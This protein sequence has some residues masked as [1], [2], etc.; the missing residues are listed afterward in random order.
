G[1]FLYV[2]PRSNPSVQGLV[3]VFRV[4]EMPVI[5]IATFIG[6]TAYEDKTLA[7]MTNLIAG[8]PYDVGANRESCRRIEHFYRR[9]GYPNTKVVL[10]KGESWEE[11]DVVVKIDEGVKGVVTKVGAARSESVADPARISHSK[12]NGGK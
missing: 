6:N 2:Q 11:R 5:E 4:F 12:R 10:E 8:R 3:L 1:K 9:N 7:E